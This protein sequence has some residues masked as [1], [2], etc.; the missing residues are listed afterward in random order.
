MRDTKASYALRM[1]LRVQ[2][3]KF[4]FGKAGSAGFG[5]R[6]RITASGFEKL[7]APVSNYHIMASFVRE[8]YL[9]P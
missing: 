3:Q 4:R 1:V 7:E 9:Y 5:T 8:E 6:G 2:N